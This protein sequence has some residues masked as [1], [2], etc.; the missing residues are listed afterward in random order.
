MWVV[1]NIQLFS[2]KYWLLMIHICLRMNMGG[3]GYTSIS[4]SNTCCCCRRSSFLRD[5]DDYFLAYITS[6]PYL[7]LF[8]DDNC[9]LIDSH[10]IIFL[11]T[12]NLF[13][14]LP[15]PRRWTNM[16]APNAVIVPFSSLRSRYLDIFLPFDKYL[17]LVW[18]QDLTC[19]LYTLLFPQILHLPKQCRS[20]IDAN[21]G[22]RCISAPWFISC[23]VSVTPRKLIVLLILFPLTFL[24]SV[25]SLSN[26]IL[27]VEKWDREHRTPAFPVFRS[28][29]QN[30]GCISYVIV[31]SRDLGVFVLLFLFEKMLYAFVSSDE[32]TSSC[33]QICP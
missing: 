31:S 24:L 5:Y 27:K 28:R 15:I 7:P 21:F 17:N 26:Q 8:P 13:P 19:R 3:W 32:F 29:G 23:K 9:F 1:N 11:R 6:S 18:F 30:L 20:V 14:I 22:S 16:M 12:L 33:S 2:S 10:S 4:C 25:S